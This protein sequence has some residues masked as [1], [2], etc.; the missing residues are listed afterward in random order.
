MGWPR[1]QFEFT[2]AISPPL[3]AGTTALEAVLTFC[4]TLA[5]HVLDMDLVI[6]VLIVDEHRVTHIARH[7]VTVEEV[8][9]IVSGDYAYIKARAERWLLVGKRR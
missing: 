6:R 9:E 3:P 2:P 4:K 7:R 8:R 5:Y 1:L